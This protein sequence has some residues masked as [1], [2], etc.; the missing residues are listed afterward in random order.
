M[1][2][3]TLETWKKRE[4]WTIIQGL[5]IETEKNVNS[6]YQVM[7]KVLE[8]WNSLVKSVNY[9]ATKKTPHSGRGYQVINFQNEGGTP[10]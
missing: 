1:A 10:G 8:I 9:F 4:K 6:G 7:S 5:V 3:K 2:K